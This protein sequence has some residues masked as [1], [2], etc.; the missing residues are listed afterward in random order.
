MK[1]VLAL[2]GLAAI[3]RGEPCEAKPAPFSTTPVELEGLLHEAGSA[4]LEQ[5]GLLAGQ[6]ERGGVCAALQYLS[7]RCFTAVDVLRQVARGVKVDA[8][9]EGDALWGAIV[10]AWGSV[11]AGVNVE[12]ALADLTRWWQGFTVTDVAVAGKG[13]PIIHDADGKVAMDAALAGMRQQAEWL[14]G[15]AAGE[16]KSESAAKHLECASGAVEELRGLLGCTLLISSHK[17]K[18]VH[19][20][21]LSGGL[22]CLNNKYASVYNGRVEIVGEDVGGAG[23][24]E[25]WA[26]SVEAG[27]TALVKIVKAAKRFEAARIANGLPQMAQTPN[28]AALAHGCLGSRPSEPL[29]ETSTVMVQVRCEQ[30]WPLRAFLEDEG[31]G[32]VGL[33]VKQRVAVR[34][35][36]V[37]AVAEASGM[38]LEGVGVGSFVVVGVGSGSV[39]DL[40]AALIAARCEIVLSLCSVVKDTGGSMSCQVDSGCASV[41]GKVA[42]VLDEVLGSCQGADESC[43]SALASIVSQMGANGPLLTSAFQAL[44]EDR[45]SCCA[46]AYSWACA[47]MEARLK[48]FEGDGQVSTACVRLQQTILDE[49]ER[50]GL[51]TKTFV[52]ACSAGHAMTA[53][54]CLGL[55][56]ARAVDVHAAD[57]GGPEAAFR[58]ACG[59]GHTDIV[60]EL[61]ALT[62]ARAVDVHAADNYGSEAAF[63]GA[64]GGGH[65]D[66]VRE[67]LALTGARAVDVHAAD[68]YGS[69]AAFREACANGHTD[70]VRE[71]LA[72]TGER[73]VNVHASDGRGSEVAFRLACS[74]GHIDT[75]RVLLALRGRREVSYEARYSARQYP[76]V[77]SLL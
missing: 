64:C 10:G 12:G 25:Q 41:G 52:E 8:V 32:D 37:C 61:L 73:E 49:G 15:E 39:G 66:I 53:C 76:K 57:K 23:D 67:L 9:P 6:R 34:V 60:R 56:G 48:G 40:E 71:L 21:D 72:L 69:E 19:G 58:G 44:E 24:V 7:F 75:V 27:A 38:G 18:G 47:S 4:L 42:S 2:Q 26:A 51:T 54:M 22:E 63:R 16:L 45:G 59:G 1:H 13:G 68:N 55:T 36:G 35:L 65:T 50:R 17:V 14:R 28:R 46:A 5:A 3:G 33:E 62:G 43:D 29:G 77:R 70:I 74:G 20:L 31:W 30:G 11:R